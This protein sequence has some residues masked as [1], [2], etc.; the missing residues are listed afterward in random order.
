MFFTTADNT[1]I[2]HQNS[3][4][5]M[6]DSR[7]ISALSLGE[8]EKVLSSVEG[9]VI[10]L[11][12]ETGE[13]VR[14]VYR[15]LPNT[16]WKVVASYSNSSMH[17][18]IGSFIFNSV[19]ICCCLMFMTW[20]IVNW[21]SGQLVK[22][23]EDG[24]K[25]LTELNKGVLN[26]DTHHI[27]INSNDVRVFVDTIASISTTL[28][29]YINEISKTLQTYSEGNFVRTSQVKYVGDFIVIDQSLD[30]ISKNLINLISETSASATEVNCGANQ[31]ALSATNLASATITQRCILDT[32]RIN[33]YE[34]D[35]TMVETM[36]L[37]KESHNIVQTMK[38]KA[39]DGQDVAD[40]AVEA[41][42]DITQSTKQISKIIKVI[43]EIADQTNLLA[44]NAAIEAA[45]A[46]E[47]GRGFAIVA[48]E[49][50]DLA[51]RSSETVHEIQ[52]LLENN[53]VTVRR[54]ETQVDLTTQALEQ[55][56]LATE[57]NDCASEQVQFAATRQ[58]GLLKKVVSETDKLAIEV[59]T[60]AAISQENVAISE[61][62]ASQS[63]Q[64]HSQI[65]KF[66]IK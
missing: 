26:I 59:E 39:I 16:T 30:N 32:V 23:I 57:D 19:I 25:A 5:M 63:E 10:R 7:S 28:Q 54:G 1:V 64:L 36:E 21:I 11:D 15:G 18:T 46:G 44:L 41:M 17:D 50:R 55:I 9:D 40:K 20:A 42:S 24:V 47:N 61:E 12:D 52:A 3:N 31:I 33:T 8:Y 66:V 49:I 65:S 62:L 58:A 34:I 35:K 4:Y 51:S 53:L 13:D 27:R 45:R 48:K 60:T 29:S 2:I 43:D 6:T 14:S 37:I 56:V 22:P 38:I